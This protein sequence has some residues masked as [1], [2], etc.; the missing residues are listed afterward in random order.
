MRRTNT[1][2]LSGCSKSR[3][4]KETKGDGHGRQLIMHLQRQQGSCWNRKVLGTGK[5][6]RYMKQWQ[7]H[8][9]KNVIY[10]ASVLAQ[11]LL[12]LLTLS[13]LWHI[14]DSSF[15]NCGRRGLGKDGMSLKAKLVGDM[16]QGTCMPAL[17]MQATV[18]TLREL[19]QSLLY[20]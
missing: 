14:E 2:F 1:Y 12:N 5:V 8:C 15:L 4:I 10:W 19:S 18:D 13:V 11:L 20:I 16:S 3:R 6:F 7:G 17:S 9:A